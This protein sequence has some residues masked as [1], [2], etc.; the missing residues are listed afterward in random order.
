[1]HHQVNVGPHPD[2]GIEDVNPTISLGIEA[3]QIRRGAHARDD[4]GARHQFQCAEPTHGVWR[5]LRVYAVPD[6]KD[7][8]V[9]NSPN[10]CP[11]RHHREELLRGHDATVYGEDFVERHAFDALSRRQLREIS[12]LT[13]CG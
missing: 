6:P 4:R 7:S 2:A 9:A 10:E 8:S 1:V 3:V 12:G 5:A 11:I 13:G